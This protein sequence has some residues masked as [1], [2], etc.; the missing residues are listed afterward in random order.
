MLINHNFTQRI[1]VLPADYQWVNSPQ[2]GVK[3]VLLDRIGMENARAT[4]IVKYSPASYFPEHY[5]PKGEEI[6]VMSGVF[7]E[8]DADYPAGWYLRNPNNSS[9]APFSHGGT[10]IF[11]KLQQMKNT[12]N[13][14]V[15]INTLDPSNWSKNSD[16]EICP[17]F[18]SPFETVYLQRLMGS[19]PF[20]VKGNL[21][22]VEI[23]ILSGELV[24]EDTSYPVGSWI[25]IPEYSS[26]VFV[27][28]SIG[29][30]F[31]IK[32]GHLRNIILEDI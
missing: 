25:R 27:A 23:L 15:R 28:G 19:K 32:T 16:G 31:Y 29:V 22:G 1:S 20:Y 14:F 21:G 17:L 4:S 12:D 13:S 10:T 6:F 24:E 8:K 9:H 2:N 7:S 3:R 18:Q 5:H 30:E 11:V 26:A